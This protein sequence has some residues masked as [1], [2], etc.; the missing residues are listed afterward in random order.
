MQTTPGI[1][2]SWN[3]AITGGGFAHFQTLPLQTLNLSWCEGLKK[4][5]T[6]LRNTRLLVISIFLFI[7]FVPFERP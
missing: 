1:N 4:K 5:Q 6:L 3:N 7:R 2:L